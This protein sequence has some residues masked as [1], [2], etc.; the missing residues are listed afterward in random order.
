MVSAQIQIDSNRMGEVESLV[1]K[2]VDGYNDGDIESFL[3][4]YSDS[5]EIYEL[6]NTL[7]RKGKA[8]MRPYYEKKFAENPDLH[9]EI[10][11]RIVNGRMVVDKERITGFSDGHTFEDLAIYEIENGEIVRVYFPKIK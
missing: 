10:V 5:V 1:Q 7:L 6:P 11:N 9:C 8:N 2:Q 3:E 4:P